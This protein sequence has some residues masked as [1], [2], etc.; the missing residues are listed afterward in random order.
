TAVTAAAMLL[1]LKLLALSP[2]LAL[3]WRL[4]LVAAGAG[5]LAAIGYTWLTG[6]EVPTIRSCVA[7]LLVLLAL[8]LGREAITLRL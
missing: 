8:S 5:A 1:V 2:T 6:A 4:P 3:R 7:A